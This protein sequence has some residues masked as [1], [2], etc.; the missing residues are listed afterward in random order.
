MCVCVL[1]RMGAVSADISSS[2]Q[3][4]RTLASCVLFAGGCCGGD[5]A[6]DVGFHFA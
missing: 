3:I 6:V 4:A 5:L 2:L 1:L